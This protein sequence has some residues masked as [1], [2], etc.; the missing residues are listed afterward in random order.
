[1]GRHKRSLRLPKNPLKLQKFKRSAQADYGSSIGTLK[2]Q[3][4]RNERN[5]FFNPDRPDCAYGNS[6]LKA[7][8][9]QWGSKSQKHLLF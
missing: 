4:T 3:H 9:F 2:S 8:N 6:L 7:Y 1:M 5:L